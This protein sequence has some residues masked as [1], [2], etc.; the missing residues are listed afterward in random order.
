[1][2][3][4]L[5]FLGQRG[6]HDF[7]SD[8]IAL[9]YIKGHILMTWDLGAGPRRIFTKRPVD[10]RFLVHAVRFGRTVDN[11]P[12]SL[13]SRRAQGSSLMFPHSLSISGGMRHLT[14]VSYR[15]IS[16]C[17]GGFPGVYL[18]WQHGPTPRDRCPHSRSLR[19]LALCADGTWISV[20]TTYVPAHPAQ[21]EGLA[22]DME[23]LF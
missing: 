8:F 21:T 10:E 18:T 7:G 9:S 5:F 2:V 22:S 15:M 12:I 19:M 6:L 23:L 14:L 11:F 4:L 16:L 3:A 20:I 13:D 17:I 1:Q